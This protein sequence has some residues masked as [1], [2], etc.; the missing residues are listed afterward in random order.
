MALVRVVRMETGTARLGRLVGDRMKELGLSSHSV[1]GLSSTTILAILDGKPRRFTNRTRAA[2]CG[3]LSWRIESI[4][5][6]LGGGEPVPA[7]QEPTV[8]DEVAALREQVNSLAEL[9]LRIEG[10]VDVIAKR[11]SIEKAWAEG[12]VAEVAEQEKNAR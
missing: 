9:V 8:A 5:S 1:P 3:A 4:D 2:L 10:I 12:V 7:D 11:L 6:I